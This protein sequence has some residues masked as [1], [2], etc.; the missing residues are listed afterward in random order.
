MKILFV[1]SDNSSDGFSPIVVNQA[2]SLVREG[3]EIQYFGI[4][5]KGYAGYLR[6][7]P[8]LRRFL[9]NNKFDVVHAHYSL[10]GIVAALAGSKP[11]VVSLM[12]SDVKAKTWFKYILWFFYKFLW[13]VT[14]VKSEDMKSS[15][16]FKKVKVI[17]NGVE[18]DKF[19]P[20]NREFCQD[21]LEWDKSKDH[22]LFAANVKRAVK[23]F[24]LSNIAFTNLRHEHK[25]IELHT[26]HN[27]PNHEMPYYYNASSIVLLSSFWEGS[28]NVIKEAMACN[29]IIVSTNVGNVSFLFGTTEGLF[30]SDLSTNGFSNALKEA[31][32]AFKNLKHSLGR[33]RI[34][35]LNL[36]EKTV[37]ETI[38][39]V[40]TDLKSK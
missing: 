20:L 40:Y 21:K 15:L 36:D 18:L 23:N 33:K 35:Y 7:I 12:G 17:P 22:I 5:G 9:K 30:T 27:V 16:G 1:L 8:K 6:N 3:V 32:I 11:L 19:K 37:A 4:Q 25:N 24:E 38:V 26:L 28:P 39:N 34:Q 13:A 29:S 31:Y 10:S 14:I 2:N